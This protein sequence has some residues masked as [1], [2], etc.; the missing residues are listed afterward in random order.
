MSALLKN[1]VKNNEYYIY[2][3]IYIY[4]ILIVTYMYIKL[5]REDILYYF[6]VYA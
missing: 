1:I 6:K 5:H 3:Y 2:I 4:I